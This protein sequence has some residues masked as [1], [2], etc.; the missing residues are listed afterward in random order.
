MKV[1]LNDYVKEVEKKVR[2][3]EVSKKLE[4]D[5]KDYIDYLQHERLIKLLV[6][7]FIGTVVISFLVCGLCFEN[8]LMYLLFG[9][10]FVLFLPY[11]IGFYLLENRFQKLCNLYFRIKNKMTE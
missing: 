9:I 4:N 10:V 3:N 8:L 7:I 6:I 11:I 5:V 2:K 1:K